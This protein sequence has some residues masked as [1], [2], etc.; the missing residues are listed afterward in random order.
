M[1]WEAVLCYGIKLVSFDITTCL[2]RATIYKATK[3][4]VRFLSN[5]IRYTISVL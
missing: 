1:S 4:A 5:Y 3:E 2:F